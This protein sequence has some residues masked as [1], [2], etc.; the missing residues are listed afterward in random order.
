MKKLLT[1]FALAGIVGFAGCAAEEDDAVIIDE[2]PLE[3]PAT[4]PVVVD[5][6]PAPMAPVDSMTM[7]M[8]TAAP[9]AP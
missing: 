1:A 8:D 7:P 9:P 4:D 5:P 2:A 6:A 3:Q